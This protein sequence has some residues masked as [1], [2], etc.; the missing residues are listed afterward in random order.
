MRTRPNKCFVAVNGF[1]VAGRCEAGVLR[2]AVVMHGLS[3]RLAREHVR[4][5]E[6]RS[7][8]GLPAAGGGRRAAAGACRLSTAGGCRLST[9]AADSFLIRPERLEL[10]IESILLMRTTESEI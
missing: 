10:D 9:A 8:G 4:G 1:S 3:V 2:N 7:A 5:L 6:R